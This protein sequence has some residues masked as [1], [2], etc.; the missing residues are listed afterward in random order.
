MAC[1]PSACRGQH[2]SMHVVLNVG[3]S[4]A[5]GLPLLITGSTCML[6]GG[7][8]LHRLC[9]HSR[10]ELHRGYR[11]FLKTLNYEQ[12]GAQPVRRRHPGPRAGGP[13]GKLCASVQPVLVHAVRAPLRLDC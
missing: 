5:A 11:A 2:A 9:L 8:E 7:V 10:V 3:G 4:G 6:C 13:P 12:V 1:P